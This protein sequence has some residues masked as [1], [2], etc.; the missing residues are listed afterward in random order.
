M[1]NKVLLILT[2]GFEE[3]EAIGTFALLSRAN[4]KV[5]IFSLKRNNIKGRYGLDLN[6][7]IIDLDS[8]C[9]LSSYST[10]FIAGGPE[11]KELEESSLF[12]NIIKYFNENNK[13]IAAIC[14]GPTL[15]GHLGI[16]ENKN[17]TCFKSM[18]ED[19]FKGNYI[20]SY[21]VKDKNI[22]S[23]IS[24]SATIDFAFKVIETIKGKEYAD[25]VKDSIYYDA[26]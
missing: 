3:I 13:Y 25:L 5:D 24:A 23:A 2:D 26:K 10:L 14:A 6:L 7:E 19:S 20:Y 22:I 9:D 11:Y 15:L 16:L 4:I 1:E 21:V 17:Y 18:N 12:I 8:N